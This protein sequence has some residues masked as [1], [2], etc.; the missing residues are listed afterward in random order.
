[1]PNLTIALPVLTERQIEAHTR[2]REVK[3]ALLVRPRRWGAT[4]LAM[5][6]AVDA[7]I[8]GRRVGWFDG[9][10]AVGSFDEIA[11]MLE[12]VATSISKD[13]GV[14]RT[15]VGGLFLFYDSASKLAGFARRFDVVIVDNTIH[16]T[17]AL[18]RSMYGD[19]TRVL[20]LW[21]EER[22][23]GQEEFAHL[24]RI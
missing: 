21:D 23:D 5:T 11:A 15:S 14:I 20:V 7:V 17:D 1:M 8:R 3:K 6:V 16:C 22:G 19:D 24:A 10:P 18:L 4:T 2:F 12:P 13:R 9:L